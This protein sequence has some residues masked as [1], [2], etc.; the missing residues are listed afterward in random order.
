MW[1]KYILVVPLSPLGPLRPLKPLRPCRWGRWGPAEAMRPLKPLRCTTFSPR[2]RVSFFNI[3]HKKIAPLLHTSPI[4]CPFLFRFRRRLFLADSSKDEQGSLDK[5]HCCLTT[6]YF[7]SYY[8][9]LLPVLLL[10]YATLNTT[11]FGSALKS[12]TKCYSVL[13]SIIF[14]TTY[15]YLVHVNPN[16][17]VLHNTTPSYQ[18]LQNIA[19]FY[20]ALQNNSTPYYNVLQKT[21]PSYKVWQRTSPYYKVLLRTTN[22]FSVPQRT[23]PWY[24]VLLRT[25]EYWC[26]IIRH[27]TQYYSVLQSITPYD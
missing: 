27:T 6:Q 12:A 13:Q 26:V 9:V 8:K 14:R 18:V 23:S 16:Y 21:N 5:V 25:T 22:N 3:S 15:Y 4:R 19:E 20:S 10:Y 7:I 24:K 2:I 17:N 11:N 1:K